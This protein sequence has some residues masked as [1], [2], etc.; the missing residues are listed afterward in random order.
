MP[1]K[2]K[3]LSI[4]DVIEVLEGNVSFDVKWI[5]VSLAYAIKEVQEEAERIDNEMRGYDP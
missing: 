4:E 5:L 3:I 2:R 1:T